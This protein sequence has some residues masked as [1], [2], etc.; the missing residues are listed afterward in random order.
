[1]ASVLIHLLNRTEIYRETPTAKHCSFERVFIPT[2]EPSDQGKQAVPMGQ[3]CFYFALVY[4]G[5]LNRLS[6]NDQFSLF[7]NFVRKPYVANSEM[8]SDSSLIVSKCTLLPR[9]ADNF[10]C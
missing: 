1:M 4:S 2:R 8:S 7:D 3:S 9:V 6:L 5:V 10:L